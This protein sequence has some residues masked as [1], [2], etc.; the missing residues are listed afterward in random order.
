MCAFTI[1]LSKI[2]YPMTKGAKVLNSA[3][4]SISKGYLGCVGRGVRAEN[5]SN[6]TVGVLNSGKRN[7]IF[8]A[9]P[10]IQP[11]NSIKR[12]LAQKIEELRNGCE[13]IHGM[14]CG[15]L[16]LNPRNNESVRSFDLYN[17]IADALDDLGVKFSMICGKEK[18][19][20]MES[21]YSFGE[22][23]TLWGGRFD[24]ILKDKAPTRDEV[25]ANLENHYQ[26]V[27]ISPE[28]AVKVIESFETANA[29]PKKISL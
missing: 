20:P 11:I 3:N 21:L 19:A 26:F 12:A 17:A 2:S 25:I 7:F 18:N 4:S 27:E 8:A 22:S 10:E 14:I 6:S 13:E 29:V 1:N 9:Y 23:T 5:I 16:E 28:Q 15:G 24:K